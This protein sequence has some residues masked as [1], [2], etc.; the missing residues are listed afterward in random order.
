MTRTWEGRPSRIA[1]RDGPWDSPAVSQRSMRAV[2]HPSVA[3]AQ[4]RPVTR[5]LHSAGPTTTPTSA[6]TSMNGPNGSPG[7][8]PP[9]PGSAGRRPPRPA[10]SRRRPRRPADP[11]PG[12]PGRSPG[13]R[14]AGRRRARAPADA[15]ATARGTAPRRPASPTRPD[16]VVGVPGDRGAHQ[17]ERDQHDVRR[18]DDP[19]AAGRVR[20]SMT[21]SAPTGT[22]GSRNSSGQAQPTDQPTRAPAT[23][24]ATAVAWPVPGSR[25]STRTR[26]VGRLVGGVLVA[27][28]GIRAMS[29]G[30]SRCP[31]RRRSPPAR[32]CRASRSPG[33][34]T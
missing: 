32:R 15:R 4:G 28:S 8:P 3:G 6:P 25:R 34:P 20:Q 11:S 12:S 21:V 22:S 2:F 18:R 29:A 10:G 17:H 27:R 16:Q 31:A 19:S 13:S 14:T 7:V 26:F 23:P 33:G 5:W 24:D 30:T 1:T 9:W